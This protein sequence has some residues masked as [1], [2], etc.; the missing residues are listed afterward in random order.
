VAEPSVPTQAG[1]TA[2]TDRADGAVPQAQLG[3]DDQSLLPELLQVGGIALLVAAVLAS[4]AA[5]RVLQ[6]RRRVA[7]GTAGA[8]WDE[9]SASALDLGVRMHPAWT[10]RQAARELSAVMRRSGGRAGE[11]GADAV[12]RLALAEETASYG[13]PRGTS[14]REP[15]HPDLH[16]ALRTTRRALMAAA[17]RR[18]RLR[19]RWWPASLVATVRSGLGGWVRRA[20]EFG[21]AALRR[22]TGTR[23]V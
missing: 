21:P 7:A 15:A 8:L 10:P 20:R 12:R 3:Q 5:A 22:R 13:P 6:R 18:G 1:P 14:A 23:A 17:P 2:R 19:A 11:A 16:A 4:P 9:L